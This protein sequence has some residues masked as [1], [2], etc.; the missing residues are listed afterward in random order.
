MA[1]DIFT[2]SYFDKAYKNAVDFMAKIPSVWQER[3]VIAA[4]PG[5]YVVTRALQVENKDST[6]YIGAIADEK[7]Y[8]L[9]I[10]LDFLQPQQDYIATIYCDNRMTHWLS[11]P[12]EFGTYYISIKSSDTLTLSLAKAGGEAVRII[13]KNAFDLDNPNQEHTAIQLSLWNQMNKQF[14]AVFK[15]QT[16]YGQAYRKD[17]GAL[18][19]YNT[20]YDPNYPG[21]GESTLTD[22]KISFYNFKDANWQGYYNK[23][24]DVLITLPKSEN[25]HDVMI[26]C[27]ASPDD[28]IY[29][30]RK[31]SVIVYDE[32][33]Q[34]VKSFLHEFN[35]LTKEE[36]GERTI[37]ELTIGVEGTKGRYIKVKAYNPGPCPADSKGAGKPSW[38]FCDEILWR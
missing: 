13:T 35:E 23:D 33:M 5:D 37:E 10:P 19:H 14:N 17:T 15:N 20:S 36:N 32:K 38:I 24:L 22:G 7:A 1:Q 27:L 16:S 3:K 4:R 12:R 34:V 28:W 30:P 2:Y 21:D 11:R 31:A 8:Q 26:H 9:N 6:W 29:F 25:V 18:V